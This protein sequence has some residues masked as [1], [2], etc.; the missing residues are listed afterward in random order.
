VGY[1]GGTQKNPTYHQLGDHSETIQMD[2]DPRQVSYEELL[3]VFWMSHAPQAPAWSRQYRAAVFFHNQEQERLATKTRGR[4][5]ARLRGR[6]VTEI[7]PAGEFYLAEAYHQKYFL[8]ARPEL[9]GEFN[10]IYPSLADLVA[11][12]AAARVN[13]YAAGYGTRAGL[14]AELPGLGLSPAGAQ[15][16]LNLAPVAEDAGRGPGCPVVR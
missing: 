16:L 9:F 2:F 4:V 3:E 12:T 6:V 11:S 7:L 1:S 8:R 13:G 5:A 15:T 10:A 14:K